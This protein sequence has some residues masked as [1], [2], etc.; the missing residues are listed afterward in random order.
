MYESCLYISCRRLKLSRSSSFLE[1]SGSAS[2]T[3]FLAGGRKSR[4]LARNPVE[5]SSLLSSPERNSIVDTPDIDMNGLVRMRVPCV[6]VDSS[7]VSG[8]SY[9]SV[10]VCLKPWLYDLSRPESHAPNS[11]S[12]HIPPPLFSILSRQASHEDL[13]GSFLR[14]LSASSSRFLYIATSGSS[15]STPSSISLF[16]LIECSTISS[17]TALSLLTNGAAPALSAVVLYVPDSATES[18]HIFGYSRT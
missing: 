4:N 8:T 12:N 6:R 3:A 18:A 10:I 11:E 16:I 15:S 14:L 5:A 1:V 13:S 9:S 2:G 7:Y 17:M